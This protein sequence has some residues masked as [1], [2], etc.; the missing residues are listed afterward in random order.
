MI[1]YQKA[2]TSHTYTKGQAH[3]YII[4]LFKD[5]FMVVYCEAMSFSGFNPAENS[6]VC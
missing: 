3:M 1:L 5:I 4:H 2:G 6:A